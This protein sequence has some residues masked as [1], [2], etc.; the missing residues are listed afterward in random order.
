M[1]VLLNNDRITDVL[2]SPVSK[3]LKKV[4]EWANQIC[5][6]HQGIGLCLRRKCEFCW[7]SL[8]GLLEKDNE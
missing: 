2:S 6:E 3:D 7:A 5:W 8:E 1:N 4:V